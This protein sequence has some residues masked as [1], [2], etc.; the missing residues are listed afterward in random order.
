MLNKK[1]N[2]DYLHSKG[3]FLNQVFIKFDIDFGSTLIRKTAYMNAF[4]KNV[5]YIYNLLIN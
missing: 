3:E 2:V 5:I 4:T 1:I